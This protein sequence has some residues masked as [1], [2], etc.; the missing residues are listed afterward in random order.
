MLNKIMP[1]NN[2]YINSANAWPIIE[3]KK[4]ERLISKSPSMHEIIFET[5]YGPSGLPHI[6]TFAE[7]VR[8]SMVKNAFEHISNLPTRLVTFSDDLD[9][10]R[11]I[12]TNIPNKEMLMQHIDKPLADVPDPYEKFNSFAEHNNSLLCSFLDRFGFNYEFHSSSK[13]YREGVFDKTLLKILEQHEK[14]L[15]IIIPT[16]GS[17]RQ[18]SYSPFLPICPET[19][20]VL[21][22][23][24]ISTN[25]DKG[26]IIYKNSKGKTVET[27]V[28]G[29][30]CKLQWKAD[31]AMRWVSLN[32]NYEMCGKDLKPS[33]ELASKITKIL[34]GI[35]PQNMI[36]ELF[37]DQN[38]EKISKSK[39][40]GLNIDEWL[41]YGNNESLALY[42]YLNPTRAKK[43]Y[44]DIIPKYIDEYNE[45]SKRYY[46]QDKA[47]KFE[48]PVWHIH[49]GKPPNKTIALSYSMLINL[50]TA[51][52]TEDEKML[53]KY[54][55]V[56]CPGVNKENNPYFANLIKLAVKY[57]KEIIFPSKNYRA[58]NSQEKTGFKLLLAMLENTTEDLNENEYQ[59]LVYKCGKES[60][61]NNL[62]DWFKAIY[63]VLLG[64]P[65]GPRIGPFIAIYGKKDTTILIKK[66]LE[67][68]T[69]R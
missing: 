7:V 67:E 49:N 54:A 10:M 16:L 22:V 51:A 31:W 53:W 18:K 59:N 56:Y 45:W 35:P 4:L 9:G 15:S 55:S 32:I 66:V 11:R 65:T 5:G 19:G 17:E 62:K 29:G 52:N 40:N 60:G 41:K 58:P 36:Y 64:Q 34:G 24:I 25:L 44:F 30:K 13:L 69:F 23:P 26:T 57:Y 63:E 43:L 33:F 50:A 39:G 28:T 46:K 14:I 2:K 42:M 8:T 6:G 37:L 1:N 47:A 21:Q 20:K 12:P 61:F 27:L 68:K 38:G 3:A 48:N